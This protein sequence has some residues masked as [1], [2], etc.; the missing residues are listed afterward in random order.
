MACLSPLK[1]NPNSS[2]V[3]DL[4]P[5]DIPEQP[6]SVPVRRGGRHQGSVRPGLCPRPHLLPLQPEQV[7]QHCYL[8]SLSRLQGKDHV[9]CLSKG[10]TFSSIFLDPR[11][12]RDEINES[13]PGGVQSAVMWPGIF[14]V[15]AGRRQRYLKITSRHSVVTRIWRVRHCDNMLNASSLR[16][17]GDK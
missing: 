9:I 12:D 3:G 10:W 8:S 2:L 16:L 1:W 4:P 17:S 5:A 15:P 11:G 14:V 6:G 13:F 7:N